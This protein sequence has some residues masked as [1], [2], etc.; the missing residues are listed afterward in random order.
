[1]GQL[2]KVEN[3]RWEGREW[4]IFMFRA[5]KVVALACVD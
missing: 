4:S 2:G 3:T 5:L 1:V